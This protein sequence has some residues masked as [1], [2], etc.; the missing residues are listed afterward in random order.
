MIFFFLPAIFSIF[1]IF[2]KAVVLRAKQFGSYLTVMCFLVF[3]TSAVTILDFR[4]RRDM[5]ESIDFRWGGGGGGTGDRAE[6][7]SIENRIENRYFDFHSNVSYR[8]C[9]A[10]HV[11]Y[12]YIDATEKSY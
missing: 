6:V 12:R 9:A 2:L 11:K 10:A 7:A 5:L 4:L 1:S 8:V 3:Q